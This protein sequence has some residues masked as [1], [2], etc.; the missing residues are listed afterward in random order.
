M[1]FGKWQST[2]QAPRLWTLLLWLGVVIVVMIFLHRYAV[3]STP[4]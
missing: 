2:P 3:L 4:H 1:A